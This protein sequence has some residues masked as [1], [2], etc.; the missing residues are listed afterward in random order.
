MALGYIHYGL[1]R[2]S[3]NRQ[4]HIM[5]G[6]SFL[7]QYYESRKESVRVEERQEAHYNMARAY[8]MLGLTHLALPFYT[9]VLQEMH[10]ETSTTA[11]D[12]VR[13][14]AYNLQ[15]L[16]AMGGNFDVAK[17]TTED[18]LVI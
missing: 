11:E 13:D 5:Q 1:K 8:H 9:K 18:S 12:L 15:T 4:Y 14:A 2:Q 3:E 16:Y 17:A 10:N 6:L 7:Y